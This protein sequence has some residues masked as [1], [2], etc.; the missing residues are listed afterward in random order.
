MRAFQEQIGLPVT[1]AP[2]RATLDA[3]GVKQNE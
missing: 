2:D 3:L 1:G